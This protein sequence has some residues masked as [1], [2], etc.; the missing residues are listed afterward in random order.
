MEKDN[1][2]VAACTY[3]IVCVVSCLVAWRCFVMGLAQYP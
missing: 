2:A 3:L 1:D